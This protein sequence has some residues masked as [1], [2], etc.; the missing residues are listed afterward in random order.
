MSL[1]A[2]AAYIFTRGG[3]SSGA[4][5]ATQASATRC[6][7][8]LEQNELHGRKPH[9]TETGLV[10]TY[11]GVGPASYIDCKPFGGRGGVLEKIIAALAFFEELPREVSFSSASDVI[12]IVSVLKRAVTLFLIEKMRLARELRA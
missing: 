3:H 11:S 7:N 2:L 5:Y 8:E 6:T 1:K 12:P 4:E 10:C 9:C